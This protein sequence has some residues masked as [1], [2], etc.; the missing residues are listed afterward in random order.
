[1][2]IHLYLAPAGAGKTAYVLSRVRDAAMGLQSTPH[3]VV[4][5][6]LQVRA[7]RR[8]LAEVG[9][10]IGVH[11]LTFDRLYAECLTHAGEIY[12]ELSQPVQYRLIRAVV[13]ELPLV[14]YQPL[15]DRPG[16]IQVLQALIGELKAARVLPE[17]FSDAVA[18]LDADDRLRE[19][20]SVYTK[21]QQRLQSHHWADRAGLGWLAIE[22]LEERSHRSAYHWP[23]LV[24]DGFDSFTEVQIGLLKVLAQHVDE[25]IVTLTGT[26]DGSQRPL[27][28][29][30]F[31]TTRRRLEQALPGMIVKPLPTQDSR[32][33]GQL[34]HLE[35]HVYRADRVPQM[36]GTGAI[37][38]IEAPD[39][40]AE[41]RAAL[42]WLKAR[43]VGDNKRPD[44]V[45]LLARSIAPYRPFVLQIAAEFGLPVR[46]V[47]GLP[48]RTN[49]AVAALLDLLRLILPD[50]NDPSKPA[51]PRRLVIEAWESPYFDWSAMPADGAGHPIGI[52]PG[53]AEMLDTAARWGRV[54]GGPTQW[55]EVLDHLTT[56][57]DNVGPDDDE[58]PDNVPVGA[59]AQALR[60]KF[61]RFV[62]RLSPPEKYQSFRDFVGW[63]E[64]LI[65]PDPEPYSPRYPPPEEPTA[66]G[67]VAAARD[68]EESSIAERDVAALQ[69]LKDVLR[70]LVWAEE[71][72][73]G[74]QTVDFPRFLSELEGA[75]EATSYRLPI[76]PD[77]GGILVANVVQARGVPF[78]AV[79]MLGMAE[80]E[81]PATLTED[82]F[83]RDA[84]RLR[85]R[86]RFNL[87]LDPS[88]E[89]AEMEYF[90]EAIT[91]PREQLLLT[92]PRL[93][94]NGAPWQASPF[95]EEIRRLVDLEPEI[96]TSETIPKPDQA[97]SWPEVMQGLSTPSED[98]S[99]QEWVSQAAPDRRAAL[100]TAA[101]L[102]HSRS[103]DAA[104]PFDG[105]LTS[106]A[107]DFSLRFGPDHTWSASRLEAYRT[108]PYLFFVGNVLGLEPRDQPAEG[109]DPLQLGSIYHRILEEVYQDP[110]VADP[111]DL[112]QLKAALRT[113]ARRILDEAPQAE[114]FRETAWWR[115]T[116][117][118]IEE[119]VRQSLEALVQI[120]QGFVPWRFE[121][122]FFKPNVLTVT[123]GSDS[124]RLHG[125]IDRID[126]TA[127][128]RLLVIDY[129]TSG[130]WAF[131][132]RAVFE[133]K[134]L[135]LPLY[136]L[137]A[138]DALR[139][140][141]P[142]EGFYWHVQQAEP[143]S[144]RLSK[145]EGGPM[146]A[147]N[148][149]VEK[150]WEA[151]RGAR[152]GDF[153]PGP[154]GEGCP[155][156]CPAAAFCW[157]YSSR[158]GG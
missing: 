117:V 13:D 113:V 126:R 94:D 17:A 36:S 136:A 21:Y 56:R 37:K 147:V 144:L 3:V 133:G 128:G 91:R 95:W 27:V 58:L 151:I 14:H 110:H 98:R 42:R 138:R 79:A 70:G 76:P 33:A 51:L 5:T 25:M 125:V 124:F 74:V 7:W 103:N 41:V 135:Q 145:F 40:A 137:A 158:F 109:L 88:T 141:D 134:K 69:A 82:P 34:A 72:V 63:L 154:P 39:R 99:L 93:A 150:A 22:V 153:T 16:F 152:G 45:A 4:S 28:H 111:T 52:E 120:T 59:A 48:L 156:Y 26:G 97:A 18:E 127:D 20:S 2:S 149:A 68:A 50:A 77:R 139:L 86:D 19:I 148:V 83:L 67:V 30:R 46:L 106:L 89:S 9:G 142:V 90:Y 92:R 108:C 122:R 44:D 118:E 10:A 81:F 140:G 65:G 155:S 131:T 115:Q 114:G 43:I 66:L 146:T 104:G 75:I 11:L 23:L 105:D 100:E 31:S 101:Y 87:P 15:I 61:H 8:R 38:L 132:S 96:M 123:D 85:L 121:A 102:F 49:P 60:D 29:R 64:M 116:R 80:G 24:V 35:A 53:D 107:D 32:P 71:A 143:S 47:D 130:P 73:A 129:K 119:K 12:T 55:M 57:A 62:Q 78:C 1:M 54:I 112:D 84:D 6:H 157:H